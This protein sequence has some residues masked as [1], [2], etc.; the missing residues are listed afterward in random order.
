[1]TGTVSIAVYADA[2]PADAVEKAVAV[3]EAVGLTVES[4]Q[5]TEDT[6]GENEYTKFRLYRADSSMRFQFNLSD[7]R[8][9][10]EPILSLGGLS[11]VNEK[12]ARPDTDYREWIDIVFDLVCR[13]A[14]QL[15]ADYIAWLNTA[16]DPMKSVPQSRPLDEAIE[17]PPVFGVYSTTVLEDLGGVNSLFDTEP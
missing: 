14:T 4:E 9:P 15:E 6:V 17:R 10:G 11:A 5:M 3:S 13:L 1:M 8:L 12:W 16:K 2:A 7:D